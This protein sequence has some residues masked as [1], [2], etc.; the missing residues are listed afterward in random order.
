MDDD[1]LRALGRSQRED[2]DAPEEPLAADDPWHDAARPLDDAERDRML[3]AVLAGDEAK[4]VAEAGVDEPAGV[5]GPERAGE[6]ELVGAS[7]PTPAPVLDLA[8]ARQQRRTAI[9]LVLGLA[10][11]VALVI[12]GARQLGRTPEPELARLPEYATSQLRGGVAVVR[13]DAP[14]PDAALVLAASD[15]IDWV[16]TPAEPVR[17]PLEVALLAEPADGEAIFVPRVDA[18]MSEAGVVRLRGRLDR[19]VALGPGSWTLT[20]LVGG[21]GELPRELEPARTHEP[22]WRRATIRVT[23]TP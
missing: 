5:S 9:A 1:L 14:R 8:L 17:D 3:E 4:H 7:P 20:L 23:V 11:V 15:E 18:V 21:R 10:A 22:H 2:L 12:F 13:G 19:F 6:P 16:V